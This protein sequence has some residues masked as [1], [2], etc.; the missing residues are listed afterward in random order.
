MDQQRMSLNEHLQLIGSNNTR[1]YNGDRDVTR[2]SFV[3]P[4]SSSKQDRQATNHHQLH[5]IHRS[6]ATQQVRFLVDPTHKTSQA[7]QLSTGLSAIRNSK[8]STH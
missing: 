1:S 6:A 5:S 8:P 4:A 2:K 3:D 7:H